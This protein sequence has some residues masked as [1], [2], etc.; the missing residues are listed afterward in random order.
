MS[1]PATVRHGIPQLAVAT[2]ENL[3]PPGGD[4]EFAIIADALD[5]R[6]EWALNSKR[7]VGADRKRN[8]I[9]WWRALGR[10]GVRDVGCFFGL[11]VRP[12]DFGSLDGM[13]I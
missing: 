12:P 13:L 9:V 11:H 7:G 5:P 3:H 8:D 4:E 1:E 10:V 6:A 2:D